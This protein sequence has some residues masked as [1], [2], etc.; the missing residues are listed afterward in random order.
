MLNQPCGAIAR[1]EGPEM[2]GILRVCGLLLGLPSM[3][4]SQSTLSTF[5]T[6]GLVEMPSA[7]A[8]PVGTLTYSVNTFGPNL[9]NALTFQVLPN[10]S[11][12]FRYGRVN[13]LYGDGPFWDRSFDAQIQLLDE[14]DRQ[15]AIALGFRD[16]L[17]TGLLNSEYIV[18][19]KQISPAISVTGGI[20]WGRLAGRSIAD[21]PFARF[22]PALSDRPDR[23]DRREIGGQ[24]ETGAWFR[25][26]VGAFG[27]V[28][29]AVTD[30]FSVQLEYS[31][32]IYAEE[33]SEAEF[34]IRSPVNAALQYTLQNGVALKGF[35]VGGA[36][37]G[38]QISWGLNASQRTIVGGREP[39]PR[40]IVS[41]GP[42]ATASWNSSA[43][44]LEDRLRSRLR[45]E[46]ISL[47]AFN[48][49]AYSTTVYVQN[50]RWDIESQAAGR[51]ARVLVNT[52]P[53]TVETFH[54][55]FQSRPRFRYRIS[56]Y[57]AVALFDPD[58]PL[59]ID[60]G[61]QL[62]LS[63]YAAPGLTFSGRFRY[64]L[65][66]NMDEANR[67]S[68]SVLPRVRS[69]AY[70]Y[71]RESDFEVNK[72][73]VRY[74][75]HPQKDVFA[76]VTAG[77]LENQYGGISVEALW[78]PVDSRLALGAELNYVR[79]RD[80]NMRLGFQDYHVLTGHASAYY[81]F[82]NG[83][84][85]QLDVGRYLAGDWG[86]TVQVHREFDNGVRIGGFFT[87]TDVPFEDFGEGAFDKGLTIDFPLSYFTGEP[88]RRRIGQ[89][90]RPILR[91]G[92]AR[93]AVDNRLYPVV[94][95]YRRPNLVAGW[96]RFVR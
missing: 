32:D 87:L 38:A 63:Y 75:W 27:G 1:K 48:T 33:A 86:A 60:V 40:P 90:I 53:P 85:G 37:F 54:L 3:G 21:N 82:D 39:A 72:L 34:D 64:P 2:K 57:K 88:T 84:H 52:L 76:R 80:F 70:L 55:V 17:G 13:N 6:P 46:G 20:G 71:A 23:E 15:P 25:G 47:D 18:A 94:R 9:R 36:H 35:V 51:A 5:G 14:T 73:T 58:D 62:D 29:W 24:I 30:H 78:F 43:R 65:L 4:F 67:P 91:D 59:R 81:D 31:S 56:P 77:Y 7:Q 61:P 95:D 45:S 41:R 10:V 28:D 79:Q 22:N 69:E 8:Q 96:G 49:D 83:F 12:T 93:V 16:F 11:G 66:G 42:L 26:Q 19:T 68:D 92:G 50:N 74:L 44:A 89:V